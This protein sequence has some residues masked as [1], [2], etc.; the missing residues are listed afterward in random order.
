MFEVERKRFES[1]VKVMSVDNTIRVVGMTFKPTHM[2]AVNIDEASVAMSY[3]KFPKHFFVKY[4]VSEEVSITFDAERV[5][6]ILRNIKGD[7][8]KVVKEGD[9]L[10]FSTEKEKVSIPLMEQGEFKLPNFAELDENDNLKIKSLH[11]TVRARIPVL[12]KELESL[13]IERTTFTV[14]GGVLYVEQSSEDG[15]KFST[16]I[17]EVGS[18]EDG[19]Y[20]F[21]TNYLKKI[22]GSVI[23]SEVVVLLGKDCPLIVVDRTN[24]YSLNFFLARL[25][26]GEEVEEVEEEVK[27]EVPGVSTEVGEEQ[28]EVGEGGEIEDEITKE[29]L[30]EG[31]D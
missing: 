4:G 6:K 16:K 11:P 2:Y 10:H 27:E 8:V 12:K 29:L 23:M 15:Y 19:S 1:I 14:D 20:M 24:D 30:E 18:V 3:A 21:D 26:I 31:A 5:L 17:A 9:E 25:V 22:F 13:G 28:E 7:I